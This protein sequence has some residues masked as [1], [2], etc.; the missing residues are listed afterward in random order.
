MI[1]FAAL[2]AFLQI[3]L[4]DIALAGDNAIAVGIAAAGL[5]P[6]QR[7]KA[8]MFGVLLATVFRI[9]FSLG[10]VQLLHIAGLLAAGGLLLIWVAWK[11]VQSLRRAFDH[12]AAKAEPADKGPIPH[13]L[14]TAILQ[15]L[16]ADVLLSLDNILGVAGVAR[17]NKLVLIAGLLV[18][19]LLMGFASSFVIRLVR[20]HWWLGYAGVT[21]ILVAAVRMIVEGIY[22][23]L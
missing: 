19:A 5:P 11:M 4:I 3:L 6:A 20:R 2:S 16:F 15:I 12:I 10:A 23:L 17:D 18:S 7:S 22:N 1:D 21:V 9:I 13:P 14:R 8:V